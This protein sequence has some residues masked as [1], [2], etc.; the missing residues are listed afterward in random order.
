M[1]RPVALVRR[2]LLAARGRAL[3]APRGG[4]HGRPFSVEDGR[5]L[6]G[7]KPLPKEAAGVTVSP[8]EG[9]AAYTQQVTLTLTDTASGPVEVTLP[10]RFGQRAENGRAFLP[11]DADRGACARR[12]EHFGQLRRRRAARGHVR[13]GGPARRQEGRDGQVPAV[14]AAARGCRGGGGDTV[15]LRSRRARADQRIRWAG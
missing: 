12:G 3:A 11:G 8:A 7:A 6:Y 5:R 1:G 14:R 15:D 10:E 4:P 13:A 2:A 9:V